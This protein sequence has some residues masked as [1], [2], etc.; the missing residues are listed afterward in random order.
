MS[1]HSATARDAKRQARK[2]AGEPVQGDARKGHGKDRPPK[3]GRNASG[4]G[5]SHR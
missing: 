1:V 2:E 5:S 3:G 4:R